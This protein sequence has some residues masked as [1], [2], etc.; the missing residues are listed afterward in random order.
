MASKSSAKVAANF[1]IAFDKS[2][3]GK[4]NEER[5]SALADVS[6]FF[7]IAE[8]DSSLKRFFNAPIVKIEDKIKEIETLNVSN[9]VLVKNFV[10]S[11]ILH[12]AFS[13]FKDV[14]A[15]IKKLS[16]QKLKVIEVKLISVEELQEEVVANIT[17]KIEKEE[18]FKVVIKKVIDRS[19]IGGF[20][21]EYLSKMLDLSAKKMLSDFREASKSSLESI[22]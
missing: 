18:G 13:D 11:L 14:L 1:A 3:D 19:L 21:V 7:E 15:M 16:I 10:K 4:S 5:M 17:S 9:N 6:S 8:K 22:I 12:N 2:F 20:K